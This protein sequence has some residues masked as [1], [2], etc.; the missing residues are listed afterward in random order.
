[1]QVTPRFTPAV[2]E[3][4][5]EGAAPADLATLIGLLDESQQQLIPILATLSE[6]AL[7]APIPEALRPPR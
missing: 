6:D 5:N 1:M 4:L 7:T 2:S 3:P